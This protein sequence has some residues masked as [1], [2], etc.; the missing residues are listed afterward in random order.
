MKPRLSATSRTASFIGASAAYPD[1][2]DDA[3]LVECRAYRL[4]RITED[5]DEIRLGARLVGT[6]IAG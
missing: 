3:D 5:H 2:G 1:A 6:A 4:R